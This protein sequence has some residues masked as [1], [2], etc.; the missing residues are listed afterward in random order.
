MKDTQISVYLVN[1]PGE[2]A[3]MTSQLGKYGINI[4]AVSVSEAMDYGVVRMIVNDTGR[5]T[6]ALSDAGYGFVTNEVVIAEIPDRP[7]ALAELSQKLA[8]AGISIRYVYA[9]VTPGGG[10]ASAVL[11]TDND[12][13]AE[14]I[15]AS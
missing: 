3:R 14:Q 10:V 7:G 12:E 9:T 13:L 8:D 11:S 5:A 2:L 4:K 1:K 15:M 6:A